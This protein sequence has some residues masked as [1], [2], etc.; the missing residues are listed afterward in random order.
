MLLIMCLRP[1]QERREKGSSD[2]GVPLPAQPLQMDRTLYSLRLEAP[3]GWPLLLLLPLLPHRIA[4]RLGC[5]GLDEKKTNQNQR[6]LSIRSPF[7][8][9]SLEWHSFF[10]SLLYLCSEL[11]TVGYIESRLDDTEGKTYSAHCWFWDTASSAALQRVPAAAYFQGPHLLAPCIV[12]RSC[13]AY[14]VAF[15]GETRCSVLTPLEQKPYFTFVTFHIL[16]TITILKLHIKCR[17][18]AITGPCFSHPTFLIAVKYVLPTHT[19]NSTSYSYSVCF[20]YSYV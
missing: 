12:L 1:T 6:F 20:N 2:V 10:W 3:V 19:V 14:I 4:S 18:L 5:V 13:F 16:I 9:R 8:L 11:W 17:N 7:P 15:S